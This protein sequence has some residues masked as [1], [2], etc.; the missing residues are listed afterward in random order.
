MPDS[1]EPISMP[2]FLSKAQAKLI[3]FS[4]VDMFVANSCSLLRRWAL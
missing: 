2:S 1:S 4:K 3:H